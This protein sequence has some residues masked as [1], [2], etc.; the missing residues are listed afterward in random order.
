N[1]KFF[2]RHQINAPVKITT[3]C[4][5]NRVGRQYPLEDVADI[6]AA[7]FPRAL[8][9]ELGRCTLYEVVNGVE[10]A[11]E[12][13][14][15]LSS[16]ATGRTAKTA[17]V[18]KS[19]TDM[20]VEEAAFNPPRIDTRQPFLQ[21]KSK[22]IK[23]VGVLS[24][25]PHADESL[26]KFMA[27]AVLM[28]QDPAILAITNCIQ[29]LEH[30]DEIP[31]VFVEGS[32]GTGKTQTALTVTRLLSQTAPVY[33]FLYKPPTKPV[34][35]IYQNFRSITTFFRNCVKLDGAFYE[36]NLSPSCNFLSTQDLH[37]FGFIYNVLLSCGTS[38]L[39]ATTEISATVETF[40]GFTLRKFLEHYISK[41]G[42]PTFI[43]DECN[44]GSTDEEHQMFRFVRNTFRCMGLALVLLGTD[45]RLVEVTDTIGNSSRT[46]GFADSWCF[47]FNQLPHLWVPSIILPANMPS[48]IKN[49]ILHSRPWFAETAAKYWNSTMNPN[50]DGMISA[51]YAKIVEDKKIFDYDF[52]K[53][54]Q[55]RLFLDSSYVGSEHSGLI[56][57]HFAQENGLPN[58]LL[59]SSIKVVSE[60]AEDWIPVTVFP[61]V[62]T[63]PL[64]YLSLTGSLNN[65]AFVSQNKS[66]PYH[67]FWNQAINLPSNRQYNL[68]YEN[69]AQAGNDGN[70][71][72]TLLVTCVCVAS[73]FH[74]V[75]GI[76]LMPFLK[77]LVFHLQIKLTHTATEVHDYQS[78]LAPIKSVRIPFLSCPGWKWPDF[79]YNSGLFGTPRRT[80]NKE[81]FDLFAYDGV[82]S[83]EC[84]YYLSDIPH[85]VMVG[86]LNRT[87]PESKLH[88]VLV[89]SLQSEYF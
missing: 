36:N 18:I 27:L 37:V 87:P 74:G 73:H 43:I 12:P 6:I 19:Q 69:A 45:S 46:G 32:S 49:I 44:I 54:G 33:Y 8:P 68:Q 28:E 7:F 21:P 1:Q 17:L 39:F 48:G 51:V 81:K 41:F 59:S 83:G 78:L 47:V 64:L 79:V 85:N 16:L 80:M 65:P 11:L 38:N 52:G 58:F 72:E 2:V 86:I 89:R 66:V 55:I 71:L 5:S 63:D 40:S 88:I 10:T 82:L 77:E 62:E 15:D 3:H 25:D 56:H 31:F 29:K 22:E 61:P 75:Q 4:D 26:A 30:S 50:L 13:D 60:S 57:R 53:L 9:V 35:A 76:L 20:E 67:W 34:Q 84:K 23:Y 42:R 24:L 70:Q 14:L